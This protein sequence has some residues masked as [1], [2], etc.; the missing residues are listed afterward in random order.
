MTVNEY[1]V[2]IPSGEPTVN[3]T[4]RWV[5]G[6]EMSFSWPVN[7]TVAWIFTS[8]EDRDKVKLPLL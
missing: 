2:N 1:D 4:I 7:L 5:Q 8:N 6:T 3:K